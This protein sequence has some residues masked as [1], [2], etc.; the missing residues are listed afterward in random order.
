[1][2]YQAILFDLDGTLTDPGEGITRSVA[3]ALE[4][5]GI[6]V[7]DRKV[8]YPFIGPPLLDSFMEFY[9]FSEKDAR[10]AIEKYR[11]YFGKQ[12]IFE[13]ELYSGV[14]EALEELKKAGGRLVL[15]TSKPEPYAKEILEH[16]H[17]MGY[18]DF[19]SGSQL[20]GTR[21]KKG[22]VIAYALGHCGKGAEDKALMVGDRKFDVLGAKACGIACAGVEFFGYAAPGEL[23]EAGAA[24]VVQTPEE[25]EDYIL[26][27]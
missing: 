2:K 21:S 8:L 25:L 26:N 24:A 16:F 5:F 27:H 6:H 3:Y 22:E 19:V 7:P 10:Q 17:L 15:A 11:E 1:M 20:D 14:P 4:S 18:F 23:A 9:G 12:G 13:N